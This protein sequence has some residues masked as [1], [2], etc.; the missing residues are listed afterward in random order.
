[1]TLTSLQCTPRVVFSEAG[2]T[3]IV[4]AVLMVNFLVSLEDYNLMII[5]DVLKITDFKCFH[6]FR[7]SQR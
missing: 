3:K 6:P 5:N 4:T 1:M 7:Q 2:L